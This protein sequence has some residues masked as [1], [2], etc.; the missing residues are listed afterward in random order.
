MRD[1]APGIHLE[2]RLAA[3]GDD[4]VGVDHVAQH[5]VVRVLGVAPHDPVPSE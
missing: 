3:D 5:E 2:P 4:D 1:P